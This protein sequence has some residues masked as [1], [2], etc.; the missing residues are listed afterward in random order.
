LQANV[1]EKQRLRREVALY[2]ANA[3]EREAARLRA[4]EEQRRRELAAKEAARQKTEADAKALAEKTAAQ[5]A[6][7]A[8]AAEAAARKAE[9][10]KSQNLLPFDPT[11]GVIRG[12]DLT[13]P[14][15]GTQQ[16]PAG[17]QP[18]IQTP[19]QGL[20]FEALPGVRPQ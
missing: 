20:N 6:A 5:E 2:K 3:M 17:Q 1:L 19:Q 8:K 15:G 11:G 13:P 14:E 10:Q 9:E 16:Q 7:A 18:V 4:V 12:E